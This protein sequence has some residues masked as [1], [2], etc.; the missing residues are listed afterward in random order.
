V[1]Q[2]KTETGVGILPGAAQLV[3]ADCK[4]KVLGDPTAL[5]VQHAKASTALE[6]ALLA[7]FAKQLPGGRLA[8][9]DSLSVEIRETKVVT[10]LAAAKITGSPV[11]C[12]RLLPVKGYLKTVQV[13]IPKLDT[14]IGS[15]TA[16]L[17]VAGRLLAPG[18]SCQERE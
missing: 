18:D 12:D 13:T 1:R 14:L 15:H 17:R 11:E 8:G 2:T 7:G 16:R 3:E 4:V 9:G 5:L 10:G 6:R